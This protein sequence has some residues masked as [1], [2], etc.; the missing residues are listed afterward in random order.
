MDA[1]TSKMFSIDGTSQ[2]RTK[3]VKLRCKQVK[4]DYTKVFFTND[5]VRE[6][7]K[8]PHSVVKCDTIISL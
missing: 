2:T 3:E 6:W 5:F 7:N 1:R 8:L 4:L